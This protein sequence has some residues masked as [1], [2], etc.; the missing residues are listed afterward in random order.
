MIEADGCVPFFS[1]CRNQK[2]LEVVVLFSSLQNKIAQNRYWPVEI[3]R[4]PVQQATKAKGKQGALEEEVAISYHGVAYVNMAPL[5][6]PGVRRCV[7]RIHLRGGLYMIRAG[8][9]FVPAQ[10]HPGF[11][12]WL[13]IRLHDTTRK[14]HTG[15]S[16]TG[17]V[18]SGFA[19]EREFRHEIPQHC[20]VN[21]E[22]YT[23]RFGMHLTSR[24]TIR[25]SACAMFDFDSHM[26]L[27]NATCAFM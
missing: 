6:Y 9:I 17:S 19:P 27:V 7:A 24:W 2:D 12:S 23:T 4:T 15:T 16:H 8:V 14:C 13:C 22:L 11:F 3:M 18:H 1:H 21:E 5:L 20:H 26:Y 25:G 10:V